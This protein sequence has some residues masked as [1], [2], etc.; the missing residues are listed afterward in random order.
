MMRKAFNANIRKKEGMKKVS[1]R[2]EIDSSYK[3]DLELIYKDPSEWESAFKNVQSNIARISDYR[4]KL[5]DKDKLVE[6][7]RLEESIAF[8]L[9]KIYAYAHMKS[10]EDLRISKYQEYAARAD[11][12][13]TSFAESTAFYAP[14]I[15]KIPE[16]TLQ[17]FLDDDELKLYAF[18]F[19][20]LLHS[21]S[22]TLSFEQEEIL[23]RAL[24][25]VRTADN[26]FTMFTD[27]DME[28]PT[29]T[30]ENGEKIELSEE[31]YYKLN[32]SS[33]RR[34]RKA[35]FEGLFGTYSKYRNTFGAL[36]QGS[37]RGDVFYSKSRKYSSCL[38]ASLHTDNIPECIYENVINCANVNAYVL[39][40]YMKL[41]KRVL[42][43]K[44]L[45]MYDL[46]VPLV[47]EPKS[48]IPYEE[49]VEIVLDGLRP[50][51]DEYCRVFRQGINEKWIDVFENEGKRKGAYSWGSYGTNPYILLNYN[52]T[53]RDV[54]TLAHEMG[55]SLHS[56]WTHKKQPQVYGDYTIFLAEVAST[57]N[58]MLLIRDLLK[59]RPEARKWLL[60]YG[61]D[62][63]RTTL[64]R[65]AMFAEFERDTHAIAEKGEILTHELLCDLWSNL[66]SKYYGR[67]MVIDGLIEIEWARI[68]HFYSAFYVYK[69]VTGFV[70]ACSLSRQ[71]IESGD[72]ACEKYLD[73][74]SK[75]SS[76]WSLDI[77]KTA[78]VDLSSANPFSDAITMFKEWL[79]EW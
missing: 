70:S 16:S 67:D 7:I 71:I 28:F 41:R 26:T 48:E 33:K 34:V 19:E 5:S 1:S 64:Y 14:E 44:E 35:A 60:N 55:H 8:E 6:F 47:E 52:G 3:W 46:N 10:H 59:K 38:G 32:R 74:L 43:L 45:H 68:P 29:I 2:K 12:L 51:G 23:A 54:F 66:N 13:N 65:Q 75:G 77:L 61:M 49:A 58:E 63:V 72:T 56:F 79:A 37:V 18:H 9:G 30:D 39:H 27:A 31:R 25:V 73:F 40:D 42:K 15:L 57:T 11:L 69:Y 53:L 36:Y 20:E 21:K 78:G 62:M 76:N 17:S 50:L 4:D 24:E 22:H